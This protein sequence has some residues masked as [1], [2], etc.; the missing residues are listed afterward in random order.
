MFDAEMKPTKD[1]RP[2]LPDSESNTD[3]SDVFPGDD[4]ESKTAHTR[5]KVAKAEADK[6]PE[7]W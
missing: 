2:L 3:E 4:R 6:H 1:R 7:K 5:R